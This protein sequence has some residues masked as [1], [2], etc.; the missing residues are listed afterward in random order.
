MA[1]VDAQRT[2]TK[3][4]V[5]MADVARQ[6]GVSVSTVSHVVN[7]TRPVS[8]SA[9]AQVRD[10]IRLSGYSPNTVARSLATSD[11]HLI[12][13]VMSALTNPYFVPVVTAIDQAGRRRGYS[14][15]LADSRDRPETEAEA[16]KMLLS[17]RVDGIVLAP[18]A[19]D[20]EAVL[21]KLED[22]GI[23]TVFIDRFGD[24]RFDQVGT[25]NVQATASLVE[26]VAALG[27]SRIAFVRGLRGLSTSE[28]RVEG[29]RLGL[30]RAGLS[31]ERNLLVSGQSRAAPAERA[32][33]ALL[34]TS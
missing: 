34:T 2:R 16:V 32:V 24:D 10:A 30:D 23:P 22:Q 13:I 19:G 12:G 26:H 11:T 28:E 8:A 7:E 21:D 29:Y 15:V 31:F 18:S 25:E 1:H 4:T 27:H 6:A 3:R 5:T 14:S 17:R 20:R 33:T 9:Q